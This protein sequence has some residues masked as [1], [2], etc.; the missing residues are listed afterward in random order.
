[1]PAKKRASPGG[2]S[3]ASSKKIKTEPTRRS[4]R[5][6]K[7]NYTELEDSRSEDGTNGPEP[8]NPYKKKTLSK[9]QLT[10]GSS[11]DSSSE[12]PTPESSQD[13]DSKQA[14][15]N[16]TAKKSVIKS[17]AGSKTQN[18][19][20]S[21]NGAINYWLMKAEPESR[22]EK[23]VDVKFS[24]D[25]L[26]RV[27][28]EP[29]DGIRNP[30]ARNNMLAMKRGERAFFYHSNCKVPGIAGI[31]EIVEEHSVD[32]SQFNPKHPYFDPKAV[33]E[34]PKWELVHVR[35]LKK[36]TKFVSLKMI[37]ECAGIGGPLEG[38]QVVRLS[39]LSVSNVTAKQW[40]YICEELAGIDPVTLEEKA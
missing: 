20:Q 14:Q 29:W 26:A 33:R 9:K 37:Q 6:T 12:Q 34:K 38:M 27:E 40:N 36:L 8:M 3:S 19:L 23:G 35:F 18:T 13:F 32:E 22:L 2:E 16:A 39:R 30:V 11:Q 21:T 24:I 31:M 7:K 5:N 25:D 4:T 17:T 10:P 1:M 28:K 15:S